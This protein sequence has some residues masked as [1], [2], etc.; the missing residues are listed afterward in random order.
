MYFYMAETANATVKKVRTFLVFLLLY[1]RRLLSYQRAETGNFRSA[2]LNS[3]RKIDSSFH[4]F[5]L[6]S[7][8]IFSKWA[9]V[10]MT[11]IS[12]NRFLFL[13]ETNK[14]LPQCSNSSSRGSTYLLTREIRYR[15]RFA[16]VIRWLYTGS[17]V[18]QGCEILFTNILRINMS[19]GGEYFAS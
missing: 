11:R 6:I 2:N 13:T 14:V 17:V 4:F 10:I 1:G 3:L 9:F 19:L 18:V 5:F 12:Q 7:I 16:I 8:L 15:D